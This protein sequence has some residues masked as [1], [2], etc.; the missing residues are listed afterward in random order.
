M[1]RYAEHAHSHMLF[2]IFNHG[3]SSL[4]LSFNPAE[5][6]SASGNLAMQVLSRVP[7]VNCTLVGSLFHVSSARCF[8]F[9]AL[10]Q[11]VVPV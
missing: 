4:S 5:V 9:K 7:V 1:H 8:C 10:L 3:N 6:P 2:Y 11:L